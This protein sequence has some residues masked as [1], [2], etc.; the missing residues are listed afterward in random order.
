MPSSIDLAAR[1]SAV[2]SL[3]QD[4]LGFAAD[5]QKVMDTVV[6]RIAELTGGDGAAIAL[7]DGEDLA[8][9]AIDG[10]VPYTKDERAP[11]AGSL[12]GDALL[13]GDIIRRDDLR[14]D[15]AGAGRPVQIVASM[16]APLMRDGMMVGVVETFA[17]TVQAFDDLAAYTLQLVAGMTSGALLVARAFRD[18]HDSEARYRML[19]ERNIA[20]VFRT[21]R[22]GQIL[23]CNSAFAGAL[24]YG[25]REELLGHESWDFYGQRGD[26][27][28]FLQTLHRAQ[29]MTNYRIQLKR[30]DGTPMRAV[31]NVSV[32]PDESGWQLLGTLVEETAD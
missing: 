29:A 6:T 10:I 26:R 30:K 3:Q 13:S 20:G 12:A 5:A 7:V 19:F 2:V 27:E 17:T 14:I 9:G 22:D 23:D 21:T 24:G 1:L 31:V 32:I 18:K 11:I 28:A 16:T 15:S 8:I 4:M 25:S